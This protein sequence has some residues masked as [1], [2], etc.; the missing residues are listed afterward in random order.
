MSRYSLPFVF[1][2]LA[3]TSCSIP[4]PSAN[5]SMQQPVA[6][7]LGS[8]STI[9]LRVVSEADEPSVSWAHQPDDA[10][11]YLS[12]EIRATLIDTRI[13]H[14]VVGPDDEAAYGMTVALTEFKHNAPSSDPS[15]DA[16]RNG[17]LNTMTA[18]VELVNRATSESAGAYDITAQSASKT[19]YGEYGD[20][21]IEAMLDA[22]AE[23][24]VEALRETSAIS[25]PTVVTSND[26]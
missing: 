5:I 7:Q 4:P 15:L 3:L 14:Q 19:V 11:A 16:E 25:T 10:A 13:V 26:G 9:S 22:A 17:G 1:F 18:K 20:V 8:D 23:S 21:G 12:D 24:I 6:T 2:F